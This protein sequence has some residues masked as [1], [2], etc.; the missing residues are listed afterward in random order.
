MK[1]RLHIVI[2]VLCS[3]SAAAFIPLQAQDYL[4]MTERSLIGTARYVGMGGAM[5]AIGGDPSAVHDNPAALGLYRR[6]EVLVTM[7]YSY[8]RT[9]QLGENE[10]YK[11]HTFTVPQASLVLSFSRDK[12]TDEGVQ[13]NNLLFSYKRTHC[14]NRT[15]YGAT[16]TASPSL[17]ALMETLDVNWDIPFCADPKNSGYDLWLNESGSVDEFGFDWSMNISNRVFVGAGINV[18]AYTLSSKGEYKETFGHRNGS[19]EPMYNKN[20]SSLILTGAGC[21]LSAGVIWRPTGWLRL[22]LGL[23]SPTL[24]T[25]N[26]YTNGELWALSDSLR[27]SYAGDAQNTDKHFYM[28]AHISLSTAFQIGAYGLI[29]LQY[30]YRGAKYMDAVHALRAGIEVIPV[31]GMYINAGYVY[32]STFANRDLYVAADPNFNRQDTY[33]LQPKSTQ[34]ASFAIGYRGTYTIVQAAYQYRWQR[35]KLFAHE[36]TMPFDMHDDT[37]RI[38]LTIGWHRY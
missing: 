3:F 9:H 26:T 25:L 31:M 5:T 29:S 36:N 7:D 14:Y 24:G 19:N 37:H 33:F 10:Y 1:T 18:Q 6:A 27:P 28:P 38:V 23:Q 32:E 35:T 16:S 2:F 15:L 8:D 34:Y 13:F 17:G 22:G 11:R 30:D 12:D 20:L 4:R 21:D